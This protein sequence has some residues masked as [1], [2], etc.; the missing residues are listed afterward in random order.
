MVALG[1]VVAVPGAAQSW[2]LPARAVGAPGGRSVMEAVRD[3]ERVEREDRIVREILAGNV[4]SWLREMTEVEMVR[5]AS[6]VRLRVLPDYLAVGSDEDHAR[7]PLSPQAAQRIAEA[8]RMSL[9]TVPMVDAIWRAA[10]VRMTPAPIPPSP[11]MTTVPVFADHDRAVQAARSEV[12]APMGALM[13]GHKKD[14]VLSARL[15]TLPGRVAI[16]GWHQPDGDP[17]QPLYTGHLDSWV[18]YSHGIR[19][20][21]RTIW[22]DDVEH[23]LGEAL[24][25]PGLAALLNDDGA[26]SRPGYSPAVDAP[27]GTRVRSRPPG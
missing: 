22:I 20:V 11:A 7:V 16:Y 26:M 1:G 12:R 2:D 15:D 13:A 24:S 3:L 10:T 25:D 14:V 23:D 5:G 8:T 9:P 18:D 6:R 17:I 27:D 19:L 4:P 21:F